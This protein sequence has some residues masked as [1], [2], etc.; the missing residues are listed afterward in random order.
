[1]R[2]IFGLFLI[3][4]V[5]LEIPEVKLLEE[6]IS[7]HPIMFMKTKYIQKLLKLNLVIFNGF[8]RLFSYI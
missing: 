4:N 6:F 3:T 8:K 5:F 7:N 2:S 1:M